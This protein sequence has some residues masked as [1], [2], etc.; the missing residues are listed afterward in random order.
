[1]SRAGVV[2]LSRTFFDPAFQR[3]GDGVRF[4][5]FLRTWML[6]EGPEHGA[7]IRVGFSAYVPPVEPNCRNGP[8]D[9]VFAAA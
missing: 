4:A 6:Q 1:M 7:T 3:W 2:A 9:F 5:E 8:R